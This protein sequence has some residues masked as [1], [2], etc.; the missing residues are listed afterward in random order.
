MGDTAPQNAD[1]NTWK[2]SISRGFNA[3]IYL[4]I[5]AAVCTVFLI[6]F[7]GMSYLTKILGDPRLFCLL[8]LK[9]VFD[10]M[11]V[12]ILLLFATFGV[13]EAIRVFRA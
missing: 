5:H 6:L 13:R 11:D 1:R 2:F 9:Y 8:P 12:V 3:C 10:A 7:T 4:T